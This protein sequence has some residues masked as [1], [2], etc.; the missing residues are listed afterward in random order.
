MCTVVNKDEPVT[1]ASTASTE[2]HMVHLVSVT[3]AEVT[4][5]EPAE[6]TT[7]AFVSEVVETTKPSPPTPTSTAI[8]Q[9]VTKETTASSTTTTSTT[10]ST[11]ISTTLVEIRDEPEVPSWPKEKYPDAVKSIEED[12]MERKTNV[13]AQR[14]NQYLVANQP[15]AADRNIAVPISLLLQFI[16]V[17]LI[18]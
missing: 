11:T 16:L 2:Q 6:L 18:I 12:K 3:E 9:Q 8:L 10:S 7:L 17:S 5:T 14:Q 1:K 15:S 13:E 4:L